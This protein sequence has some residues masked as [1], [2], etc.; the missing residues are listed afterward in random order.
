MLCWLAR[1]C[2][3]LTPPQLLEHTLGSRTFKVFRCV[4]PKPGESI[5]LGDVWGFD[6]GA[7]MVGSLGRRVRGAAVASLHAGVGPHMLHACMC[8]GA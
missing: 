5:P 1:A 7:G 8:T 6:W 3:Y 4:V 2:R